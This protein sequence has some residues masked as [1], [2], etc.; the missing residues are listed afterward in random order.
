MNQPWVYGNPLQYSCLENPRGGGAW[1]AAIYV[2]AQSQ[3]RLTWLSSSSSSTRVPHPEP[4]SHL[5]PHPILLGRP[6]APAPSTLSHAL[7]LD[8][9]SVSHM[10][11]YMLQCHPLKSSYLR[12]LPQSPK[13]CS[14]HLCL[15]CCL[16]YRVHHYHLSKFH[17]Y[18]LVYCIG[19]F[20]SDL[21]HSV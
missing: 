1:W 19:V 8:W 11:I 14:L 13:I 10:A 3:T 17:I 4:P 15:F 12:L 20:L 21:L 16:A 18:T 2:V 6:S 9:R 7:N 5:P